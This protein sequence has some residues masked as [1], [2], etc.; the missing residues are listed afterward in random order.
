VEELGERLRSFRLEN[1]WS[2]R[3]TAERLGVS[4][5]SIMRWETGVAIPNDYNRYKIDRLLDSGAAV[6]L[7][8]DRVMVQLSLFPGRIPSAIART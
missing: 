3:A 7:R 4:I 1:G 8:G 2:K 5:P 6:A